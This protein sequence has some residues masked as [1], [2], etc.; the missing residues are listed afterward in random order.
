[1]L[2]VSFSHFKTNEGVP[3]FSKKS[4]ITFLFAVSAVASSYAKLT[5]SVLEGLK[6]ASAREVEAAESLGSEIKGADSQ[7]FEQNVV[8]LK[9]NPELEQGSVKPIVGLEKNH[10]D[11]TLVTFTG[12]DKKGGISIGALELPTGVDKISGAQ[13]SAYSYKLDISTFEIAP[14]RVKKVEME[15]LEGTT[16]QNSRNP[17]HR[18]AMTLVRLDDG[19]T[20]THTR[21]FNLNNP[22]D[23]HAFL[24]SSFNNSKILGKV[25][26]V[27]G[28]SSILRINIKN[29]EDSSKSLKFDFNFRTESEIGKFFAEHTGAALDSAYI[30]ADQKIAV[31]LKDS[32]GQ[33]TAFHFSAKPNADGKRYLG[34]IQL[35][36]GAT[37]LAVTE[38]KGREPVA[39]Q[40]IGVKGLTSAGTGAAQ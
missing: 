14:E 33:V 10:L 6:G 40:S 30:T 32:S 12:M 37:S 3:M 22:K 9:L 17:N 39:A 16:S 35:S 21:Q 36:G 29:K 19:S 5:P 2:L 25:E 11:K 24:Q 18:R 20:I 31:M 26:T 27:K 13:K 1:V 38:I 7:L 34:R 15:V 8:S 23:S 4:S 28:D